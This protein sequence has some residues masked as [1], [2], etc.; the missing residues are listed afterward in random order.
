[1]SGINRGAVDTRGFDKEFTRW[2]VPN[3]ETLAGNKTITS[4]DARVQLLNPNSSAR[5]VTLDA[6]LHVTG[7][8]IHVCN[9]DTSASGSLVILNS[10]G[11]EVTR[12][13][14]LESSVVVYN[15][16]GWSVIG[17]HMG[18]GTYGDLYIQSISPVLSGSP[19]TYFTST[20]VGIGASPSSLFHV[21]AAGNANALRVD[22][23]TGC[24]GIGNA[25]YSTNRVTVSASGT[26]HAIL[27]D[28]T[29]SS[30]GVVA[31]SHSSGV[32][33][34]GIDNNTDA[35]LVLQ[36]HGGTDFAKF[37]L[38][39]NY[40]APYASGLCIGKA[41]TG[42]AGMLLDIDTTTNKYAIGLPAL[43]TTERDALTG[44]NRMLIY[45]LT[46]NKVQAY[47]AG[48]WVDLH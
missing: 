44:I 29:T 47:A 24:V 9:T 19:R 15:G 12:C 48:A 28:N 38:A 37:S 7:T 3:V 26:S 27:V 14:H 13:G 46:T 4:T 42:A 45:N 16:S 5:N 10:A 31:F 36:V 18:F 2:T 11:G 25:S 32:S 23:T 40:L 20:G 41:A 39:S 33:V 30:Q 1:M 21:T 22:N 6:S 8:L 34:L 35:Y 43:T 17:H